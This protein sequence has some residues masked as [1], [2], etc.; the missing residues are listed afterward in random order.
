M[1]QT[2]SLTM[3]LTQKGMSRSM[4]GVSLRD[5]TRNEQCVDE[6]SSTSLPGELADLSG[7]ERGTLLADQTV[8]EP[9]IFWRGDY[10]PA[11]EAWL[12]PLQGDPKT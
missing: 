2:W 8:V 6:Q 5:W 9:E 10:V 4:V 1:L 7:N 12:G 11:E 3:G